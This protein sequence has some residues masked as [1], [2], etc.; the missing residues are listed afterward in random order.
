MRASSIT[1]QK[2]KTIHAPV[3]NNYINGVHS[4]PVRPVTMLSST[5]DR[6]G[7][8]PKQI[9]IDFII[10]SYTYTQFQAFHP[11]TVLINNTTSSNFLQLYYQDNATSWNSVKHSETTRFE[12]N[13]QDKKLSVSGNAICQILKNKSSSSYLVQPDWVLTAWWYE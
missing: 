7:R 13:L 1:Q 8:S 12:N 2:P 6:K 10:K 4:S 3:C 11:T 9:T 5:W